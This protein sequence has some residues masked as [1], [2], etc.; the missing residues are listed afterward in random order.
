MP[1]RD[2]TFQELVF[3][4]PMTSDQAVRRLLA[5]AH[6]PTV[7]ALALEVRGRAGRVRYLLGCV[8]HE[9]TTIV[10]ALGATALAGTAS[11]TD[12]QVARRLMLNTSERALNVDAPEV[13]AAAVLGALSEAGT[14]EEIVLQ[15]CLGARRSAMSVPN[16][17]RRPQSLW[18]LLVGDEGRRLDAESRASLARKVALPGWAATVRIAAAAATPGRRRHLLLGLLGALRHLTGPGVQVGLTDER[19][20]RVNQVLRPWRWPL[21]LN[22]AEVA[23]MAALPV[24]DDDLP[25]LPPLHPKPLPPVVGPF[26]PSAHR[27]VVA[28]ATAPGVEGLP[29]VTRRPSTPYLTFSDEALLRHLVVTGPTGVG[30]STLLENLIIQHLDHGHGLILA[31]P[32]GDLVEA[33]LAHIPQHRLDDVVVLDPCSE[34]VVGLNPLAGTGSPELRAEALLSVFTDMFGEALGVRS[35]DILFSCLLTLAH[36]PGASLV[37]V[38]RL[39]S[40]AAFR[41]KRVAAVAD[42]PALMEFWGWWDNLSPSQQASVIAPLQN[43]LRQYL[44]RGPVR[45][46]VGQT[47]P[48]F[49]IRQVFTEQKILLVPLPVAALGSEGSALLGS[50]VV[51]AAWDAARERTLLPANQRRPV[52]VCLDEFQQFARLPDIEDA[53]ATS[54][55][56]GVGWVLAHQHAAQ[57]PVSLRSAVANNVRSRVA[58]QLAHED[59]VAM[60]R[61]TDHQS[62]Y[63]LAAH[64][65]MALPAF[66]VYVSLFENGQSQPFVSGRTLPSSPG[67]NDVA[68]LRRRSAERYGRVREAVV[69]VAT[70]TSAEPD[71][72]AMPVGLRS[73]RASGRSSARVESASTAVPVGTDDEPDFGH[74]TSPDASVDVPDAA[75]GGQP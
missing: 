61:T 33:V 8:P 20:E 62:G 32:K 47:E 22:A 3:P 68:A 6:E 27:L 16:E 4:R 46:V 7:S 55:S 19:P 17:V 26:R 58:F 51:A 72:P 75:T 42:D 54:R 31:E 45:A 28:E 63:E 1:E 44:L 57:L 29:D 71:V 37:Q 53:L 40:D 50:L 2:L 66:N 60:A 39:L 14:D 35:T 59:A 38:P 36:H 67:V 56:L 24:G 15:V 23:A 69:E 74:D 12:T 34:Q 5:L 25:G 73:R 9:Q 52:M 65:F 70:P 18:Q 30:K 49:D 10:R 43:K 48:R 13:S 64:D 21:R 41:S 11:R